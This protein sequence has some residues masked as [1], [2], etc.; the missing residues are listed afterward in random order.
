MKDFIGKEGV[1]FAHYAFM[2][3]Q[4]LFKMTARQ[5]SHKVASKSS[6]LSSEQ[7][8]VKWVSTQDFGTV[9]P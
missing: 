8:K 1:Y 3:F 4:E 6:T 9:K 2:Y 5:L 7:G